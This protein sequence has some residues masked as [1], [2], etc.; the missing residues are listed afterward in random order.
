MWVGTLNELEGIQAWGLGNKE[1]LSVD[2][3]KKRW[4]EI[5]EMRLRATQLNTCKRRKNVRKS[6]SWEQGRK[7]SF[8][9][10]RAETLEQWMPGWRPWLG[11]NQRPMGFWSLRALTKTSLLSPRFSLIFAVRTMCYLIVNSFLQL[12]IQ[13][14]LVEHSLCIKMWLLNIHYALSSRYTDG[15]T[16]SL[17]SSYAV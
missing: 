12:F 15:K 14:M 3:R 10:A 6:R 4:E 5:E 17:A 13:Q 9:V 11:R 8:E 7:L 1:Y 2:L 16:A